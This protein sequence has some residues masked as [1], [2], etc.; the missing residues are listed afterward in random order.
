MG[1]SNIILADYINIEWPSISNTITDS[2]NILFKI[3]Y[4]KIGDINNPQY[5]ILQAKV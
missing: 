4:I 1:S 3:Y 2:N 5:Y